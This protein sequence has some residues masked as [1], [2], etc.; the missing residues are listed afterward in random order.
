VL[1]QQAPTGVLPTLDQNN[2]LG[3]LGKH[4][5]FLQG[6]D[7][8]QGATGAS[9]DRRPDPLAGDAQVT[10]DLTGILNLEKALTQGLAGSFG[11]SQTPPT[12]GIGAGFSTLDEQQKQQLKNLLNPDTHKH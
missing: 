3:G 5:G 12:D 10:S 6:T 9:T 7:G 2:L 4:Q 8:A 1:N 11:S